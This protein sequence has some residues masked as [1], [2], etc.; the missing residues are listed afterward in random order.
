MQSL[1]HNAK[2]DVIIESLKITPKTKN[3]LR[4]FIKLRLEWF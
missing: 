4:V 1:R 2:H 3:Q